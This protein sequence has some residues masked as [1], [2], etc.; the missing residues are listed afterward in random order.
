MK[1]FIVVLLSVLTVPAMAGTK[2]Y[3]ELKK[4]GEVVLTDES[5]ATSEDMRRAYWYDDD[6]N[7]ESGCWRNEDRTIYF[8]WDNGGESRYPK[9]KVK[10]ANNW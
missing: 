4:G 9:K 10:V 7:T 1:A 8:K 6:G 2:A 3:A 5:C